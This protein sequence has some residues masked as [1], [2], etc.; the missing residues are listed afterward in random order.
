MSNIKKFDP[1][2]LLTKEIHTVIDPE[3]GEVQY[4]D[5]TIGDAI[6]IN[7]VTGMDNQEK[8]LRIVFCALSKAYP[9]L[10]FTDV[11]KFPMKKASR[12]IQLIG[13]QQG[14]LKVCEGAQ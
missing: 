9:N 5:L 3:L 6:G 10:T 7:K 12:L 13:E 14:F 2:D 11:E 4:G 8:G 1:K